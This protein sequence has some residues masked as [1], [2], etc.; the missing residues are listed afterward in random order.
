MSALARLFGL[1]RPYRLRLACAIACMV[2]YSLTSTLWIALI[3]PFMSV[4]FRGATVPAAAAAPAGRNWLAGVQQLLAGVLRDA[5]P[6]AAFERLCV[7]ILALFLVRNL[8]D[9]A[10][11]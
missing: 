5:P 11:S 2:V 4:L 3:Q 9:Y 1:L 10:A 8:A 7:V 6:F